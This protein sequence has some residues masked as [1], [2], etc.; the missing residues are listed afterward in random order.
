MRIFLIFVSIFMLNIAPV[1]A[2]ILTEKE[3][4][5]ESDNKIAVQINKERQKI[6]EDIMPIREERENNLHPFTKAVK[7]DTGNVFDY[8]VKAN[9]AIKEGAYISH[10]GESLPKAKPNTG[11]N[12]VFISMLLIAFLLSYFFIRPKSR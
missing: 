8:D 5:E 7:E 1:Y 2:L 6:V 3:Y 4:S 9:T 11:I 12:F 10:A